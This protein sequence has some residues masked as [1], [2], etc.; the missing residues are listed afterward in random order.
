MYNK[1]GLTYEEYSFTTGRWKLKTKEA[2]TERE[3]AILMLAG[4]GKSSVEIA[5]VLCKGQ[6]TIRNQIKLL[7]A[8]LEVHSMQEAI[9]CACNHRMIYPKGY[10][11]A[12]RRSAL[13]KKT[14]FDY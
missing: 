11:T 6:N 2:L 1:D 5:D 3:K 10:R 7:F 9:E 4:Q 8:K 12:S 13:Q 14:G